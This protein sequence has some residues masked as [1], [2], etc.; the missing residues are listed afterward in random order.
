MSSLSVYLDVSGVIVMERY[1]ASGTSY[2]EYVR[3]G[4]QADVTQKWTHMA[5]ALTSTGNTLSATLYGNG[6]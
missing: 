4:T 1:S 5:I 6:K 3:S 2:V